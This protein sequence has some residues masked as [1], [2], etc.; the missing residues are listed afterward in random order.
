MVLQKSLN[1]KASYR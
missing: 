1:K